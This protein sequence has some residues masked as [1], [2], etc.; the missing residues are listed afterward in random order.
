MSEYC[1]ICHAPATHIVFYKLK[2][3]HSITERWRHKRTHEQPPEWCKPHARAE[4]VRRNA[5]T[6]SPL[7]LGEDLRGT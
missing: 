2:C 1:L 5:D 7:P 3:W 6:M 4:V